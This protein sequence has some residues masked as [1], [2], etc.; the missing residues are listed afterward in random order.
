MNRKNTG[1]LK[2]FV[3]YLVVAL[4]IVILVNFGQGSST[5]NFTYNEFFANAENM[6]FE[7]TEMSVGNTVV[8]VTGKY[9]EGNT[10]IPFAVSVPN[11]P[12]NIAKLTEWFAQDSNKSVVLDANRET[13][14]TDR[15]SVV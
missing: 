4:V 5:K 9:L 7:R 1:F 11:T 3:P 6:K 2:N 12:E 13:V 8:D 14:M 10:Q 15:K